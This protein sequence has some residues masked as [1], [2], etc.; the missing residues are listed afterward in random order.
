MYFSLRALSLCAV[1]VAASTSLTPNA[2]AAGPDL[3]A[4]AI[5]GPGQAHVDT[6]VLV[7]LT[8]ANL[9]DPLAGNFTAEVVLTPDLVVDAGDVVVGSVTNAVFGT[10]GIV[11]HV[12]FGMPTGQY[13]WGLRVLPAAGETNAANNTII[14][15]AT[16]I[17]QV[18]LQLDDDSPIHLF[19]RPT[20]PASPVAEVQVQNIGTTG[21]I[22]V[23]PIFTLTPAPW[24]VI[25]PFTSYA[26][27]GDDGNTVRIT[28]DPTGLDEGSYSTTV[29][30]QNFVTA[31]DFIDVPVTLTVGKP[32]FHVG[33]RIVGHIGTPGEKDRIVF[34]GL[35]KERLT[36]KV[37]SKNGSLAPVLEIVDPDGNIE[38]TL[39]FKHSKKP[40]A[41]IVTL[42]TSGV[43]TLRVSGVDDTIG[44]FNIV[45]RGKLPKLANP[46]AVTVTGT[47][48]IEVPVLLKDGAFL[49]LSV[50]PLDSPNPLVTALEMPGGTNFDVTGNIVAGSDGI[51]LI[52]DVQILETGRYEV[53]VD[54]LPSASA[55]ARVIITPVQPKPVKAKVYLP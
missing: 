51:T 17:I 5:G 3:M 29:R 23:V 41:K 14:G 47:A 19:A 32:L 38:K 52:E 10:Q 4:V 24:L 40:V 43:Y 48:P 37:K 16:N 21:S 11:V 31:T 26:V 35:E 50:K 36:L 9:G 1:A 42:K 33:D 53:L 28:A 44:H 49:D 2:R 15:P 55:K 39:T 54:G 45:T 20:D 22:I 18:V 25:D 7:H 27:A 34:D 13:A 8:V 46:R 6:G 12:P 30:F